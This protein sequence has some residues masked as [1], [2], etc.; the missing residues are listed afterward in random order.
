MFIAYDAVAGLFGAHHLRESR[1]AQ[2]GGAHGY[3]RQV[4][5]GGAALR[6]SAPTFA[7]VSLA[8]YS[9][10]ASPLSDVAMTKCSE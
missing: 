8:A 3:E 5:L 9:I 6:P 1:Y 7:V 2:S 10:V 4:G